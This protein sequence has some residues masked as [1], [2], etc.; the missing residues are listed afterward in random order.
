MVVANKFFSSYEKL[1][2]AAALNWDREN[3]GNE[4]NLFWR[5]VLSFNC[6][7]H[8]NVNKK[9]Y[10]NWSLFYHSIYE[11]SK[12]FHYKRVTLTLPHSV[13]GFTKLW[14]AVPLSKVLDAEEMFPLY[15]EREL[16]MAEFISWVEN[17]T[18]MWADTL[19]QDFS[20]NV[21]ES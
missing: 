16:I 14:D 12:K 8:R 18:N 7:F 1:S 6:S 15:L 20:S 19:I 3:D 9:F 2:Q 17:E 11:A 5:E 13:T 21:D 10:I 4:L